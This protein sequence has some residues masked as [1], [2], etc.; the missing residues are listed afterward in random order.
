MPPPEP[1]SE[2]LLATTRATTRIVPAEYID[3]LTEYILYSGH[4]NKSHAKKTAG[5]KLPGFGA[6]QYRPPQ[7]LWGFLRPKGIH[8]G[9]VTIDA[10]IWSSFITS[11]ENMDQR[12]NRLK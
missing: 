1:S 3:L 9:Y 11:Q 6:D 7:P 4:H 12:E 5:G 2:P 8:V 10:A